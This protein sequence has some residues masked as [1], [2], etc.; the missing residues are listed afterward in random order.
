MDANKYENALKMIGK[1][2]GFSLYALISL[3]LISFPIIPVIFVGSEMIGGMLLLFEFCLCCSIHILSYAIGLYFLGDRYSPTGYVSGGKSLNW[4]IETYKYIKRNMITNLIEIISC[5][6]FSVIY[7][8]FLCLGLFTTISIC[9]LVV[10]IIA[11]LIFYLFYQK[12]RYKLKN[13]ESL[14]QQNV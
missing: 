11:F 14:N 1:I 10:S 13:K 6:L 12:Q 3:V 2:L 4:P 7:I 5:A 9:G 8:V